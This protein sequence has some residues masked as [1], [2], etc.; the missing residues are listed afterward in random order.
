MG[1]YVVR[2]RN[3]ERDAR[4]KGHRHILAMPLRLFA[5]DPAPQQLTAP[6]RKYQAACTS[7]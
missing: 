5:G 2:S 4:K 6:C 3:R 1:A 7:L